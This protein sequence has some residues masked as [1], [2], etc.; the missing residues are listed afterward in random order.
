MSE[1]KKAPKPKVTDTD[2]TAKAKPTVELVVR[3]GALKRYDALKKKTAELPV[4]VTWDR[5][6]DQRRSSTAATGAERR[7]GDRR[8]KPPATWELADFVVIERPKDQE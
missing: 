2:E 5:R 4:K 8:Q 1:S 7:T 6:T 3:R